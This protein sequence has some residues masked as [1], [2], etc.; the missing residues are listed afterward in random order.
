M[1]GHSREEL[2]EQAV[3]SQPWSPA[4]ETQPGPLT[5]PCPDCGL[6]SLSG[7]FYPNHP[8]DS[9]LKFAGS[10]LNECT[11]G[12]ENWMQTTLE[13]KAGF[14]EQWDLMVSGG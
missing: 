9:F 4:A 5:T 13:K 11:C 14:A 6:F 2:E 10:N 1:G 3:G 12:E 7:R 8:F